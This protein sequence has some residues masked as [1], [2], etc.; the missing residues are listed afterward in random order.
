MV[1]F[2]RSSPFIGLDAAEATLSLELQRGPKT[3][4]R[5]RWLSA[6]I[7][8]VPG[9]HFADS[10]CRTVGASTHGIEAEL[11]ALIIRSLPNLAEQMV[12]CRIVHQD[13]CGEQIIHLDQF[14][15]QRIEQS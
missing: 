3:G 10:S 6:N 13:R 5:G 4:R 12:Q 11:E 14:A 8:M 1:G 9:V 15:H 7:G 2:T